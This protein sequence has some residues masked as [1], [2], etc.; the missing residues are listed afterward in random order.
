MMG[1]GGWR[2]PPGFQLPN[3]DTGPIRWTEG[4]EEKGEK[5]RQRKIELASIGRV[6]TPAAIAGVIFIFTVIPRTKLRYTIQIQR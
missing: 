5:T 6:Q 3:R 1:P 2:Q 4:R